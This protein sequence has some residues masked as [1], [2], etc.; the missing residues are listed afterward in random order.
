V[1]LHV[2]S[3]PIEPTETGRDDVIAIA[4]GLCGE[5][6][7]AAQPCRGGGNNRVHRIETR[8]AVFAMKFY[9]SAESDDRD[10]LGHEFDGL[11]FLKRCGIGRSLPDAVAADR[12]AGCALY[13]WIE[14]AVPTVHGVADIAAVVALLTDLHTARTAEGAPDLP[15]ATEAVIRL[16]DLLEQIEERVSR[17]ASIT[18]AEP[19]L[20]AFLG[21]ELQPELDR[22]SAALLEWDLDA[23]LPPLQRTLSPSDFGFHNSLRRPDGSLSFI[24]FE[25]FGWDDSVKLTADFLWHPGMQLSGAERLAFLT[26]VAHLYRADPGFLQRLDVCYPL[27]G[28]RWILIILN[29]FVPRIWDRRA[30]SGRGGDWDDAKRAQMRK[31]RLALAVL[32]SWKQGQLIP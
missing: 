20:A 19:E 27:Y 22:R 32:R 29:E 2:P 24:D 21:T 11:R 25:Y 26:G 9:G 16:S 1:K 7:I 18:A 5:E 8:R 17:L 28:I 12:N 15:R 10:R 3:A 6:V 14:G 30:L 4:Q 23:E 13:E 31:A